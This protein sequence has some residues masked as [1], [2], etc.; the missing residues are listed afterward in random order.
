MKVAMLVDNPMRNDA[1]VEKEARTLLEDGHDVTI[2][3]MKEEI[4]SDKELRSGFKIIRSLTIDT[5]RPFSREFNLQSQRIVEDLCR[6]EF[7]VIHCHDYATYVSAAP[8]KFKK[9]A[10]KLIYD[11]HEYLRGWPWYKDISTIT[12]RLKGA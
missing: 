10:V 7:D 1:R 4:S 11:A 5:L 2:F 8:I 12:N 6:G 3:A 9:P